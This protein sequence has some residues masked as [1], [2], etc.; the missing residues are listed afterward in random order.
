MFYNKPVYGRAFKPFSFNMVEVN[1]DTVDQWRFKKLVMWKRQEFAM[2]TNSKGEEIMQSL[3]AIR[4]VRCKPGEENYMAKLSNAQGLEIFQR[5]SKGESNA[6]LASEFKVAEST[7]SAIKNLR[8]RTRVTLEYL[9]GGTK[10]AETAKAVVATR[11]KGHKLSP[12]MAIF[13]RRDKDVN[14]LTVKQI[15]TKYCVTERTI[16]RIVKGEMYEEKR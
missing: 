6:A 2:F 4:F 14:R 1:P 13:I 16:Q 9:N 12:S 3:R 8:T 15:A 5:A 7:V 10:K 11:N